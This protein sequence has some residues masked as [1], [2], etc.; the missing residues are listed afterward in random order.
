M[1]FHVDA[2]IIYIPPLKLFGINC[3][4]A[5]LVFLIRNIHLYQNNK[6]IWAKQQID[7][8]FMVTYI[9]WI[10][11]LQSWNRS[12]S[13]EMH[14]H[15][16]MQ[17]LKEFIAVDNVVEDQLTADEYAQL[18]ECDTSGEFNCS[19][20]R[21]TIRSPVTVT[22][23]RQGVTL[24]TTYEMEMLQKALKI[25]YE[26]VLHPH[27]EEVAAQMIFQIAAPPEMLSTWKLKPNAAVHNPMNQLNFFTAESVTI[28]TAHDVL[29]RMRSVLNRAEN[30]ESRRLS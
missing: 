1:K 18:K 4:S 10:A 11:A 30:S 3:A 7:L 19:L 8:L 23:V 22:I 29:Q 26:S 2:K 28:E 21:D 9:T 15:E 13:P 16:I 14:L 20:T 25:Q 24:T 27:A 5:M 17:L 12:Q 6:A